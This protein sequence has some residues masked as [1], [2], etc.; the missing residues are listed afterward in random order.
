MEGRA[1]DPPEAALAPKSGSFCLC[2]SYRPS[3]IIC[4]TNQSRP[5]GL[6]EDGPHEQ[7]PRRPSR[8]P[9][10]YNYSPRRCQR[11]H[12][13]LP[14]RRIGRIP[15]PTVIHIATAIGSVA[16]V[17]IAPVFAFSFA[18]FAAR[19][20]EAFLLGWHG[21]FVAVLLLSEACQ[22]EQIFDWRQL[23]PSFSRRPVTGV[24]SMPCT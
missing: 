23:Q 8:P 20:S 21:C 16:A 11:S 22:L 3:S 1:Q 6:D 12:G 10:V 15:S 7:E 13:G 24:G 9:Y 2:H 19:I 17:A 4:V 14:S 5:H 18:A